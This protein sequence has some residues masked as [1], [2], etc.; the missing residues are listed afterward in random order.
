MAARLEPNVGEPFRQGERSLRLGVWDGAENHGL[1]INEESI[2]E[3]KGL[4]EI[5]MGDV[6]A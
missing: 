6:A 2:A 4:G 1:E 3:N 5:D